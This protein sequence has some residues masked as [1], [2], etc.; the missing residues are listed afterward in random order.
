MNEISDKFSQFIEIIDSIV[1]WKIGGPEGMPLIVLWL[2]AGSLFFTIRMKFINFRAFIHAIDVVRGEYED[3]EEPGEVSH[4]QALATALS[5][6]LG[7][8][9]IAAAAVAI[10]IGG[11]GA[12]F[13]MT[14]VGLL[15]MSTKFVECTLGVKY[16][17]VNPDGTIVGGPM[18][19]LSGGLADIGQ[20]NLGRV[21]ASM[22]CLLALP[23]A[24]GAISIYQCNQSLA[25]VAGV[26]PLFAER[27]WIYGIIMTVL[28]GLVILGG[29]QRIAQVAGAIVPTM[30]SIYL[31]GALWVV[32]SNITILPETIA[33]IVKTAF[34]PQAVAGGF[35]GTL[36]QGLRRASFSCAAGMGTASIAHSVAKTE[37]PIREGIVSLLEPFIDTVV[38]CNLTAIVVII[39]GAYNNPEFAD[40]DGAALTSA[41][42]GSVISWFPYL[43]AIAIF[44]FAFSTMISW[45]YYSQVCWQYLFG[46]RTAII[47]KILY[48]AAIL[49]GS[50]AEPEAVVRF[51]DAVFLTMSFPN[52][53]GA[54]LLSNRVAGDL[55]N[56]I[57]R[58][59]TGKMVSLH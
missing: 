45:G 35:V 10:A 50:I 11:P 31:F 52:L 44:F 29:I 1:F 57:N 33:T 19:Y 51:S 40:L 3:P 14:I 32:A 42:F 28:V 20:K 9:N 55:E 21:L 56:Y 30:C 41:A 17:I 8:A 18:Y 22:F 16:R 34:V 58:L 39:S 12:C 2:V 48:L 4:F 38:I 54:Y 24:L 53:L 46:D 37:E 36:V 13:W 15:G 59:K 5:A 6:T 26:V 49:V 7:V 47:Y 43:L 25:V 23:G 27:G